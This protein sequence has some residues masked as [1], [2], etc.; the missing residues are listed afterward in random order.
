MIELQLANPANT[1][2]VSPVYFRLGY[3]FSKTF[4]K[5]EDD[6][7]LDTKHDRLPVLW[8]LA[9]YANSAENNELF[10]NSLPYGEHEIPIGVN[11]PLASEYTISLREL[12]N[13][14]IRSVILWDKAANRKTELLRNS[15]SFLSD[16]NLNTQ[17]RFVVFINGSNRL[18]DPTAGAYAY[19]E[20]S[21][22]TVMNL[23]PGDKIQVMNLDGHTVIS[24][25]AAGNTFTTG[26]NQKG[27]YI[28]TANNK[29]F[30]VLNK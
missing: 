3:P 1:G 19:I 18:D 22:L 29:T 4:V 24:T 25:I 5:A 11:A 12:T 2:F 30:K 7:Q 9:K 16:G 21:R 14:T 17:D 6:V 27:V 13:E 10:V 28:V 26:L 23:L 8:S 15:Y 20:N